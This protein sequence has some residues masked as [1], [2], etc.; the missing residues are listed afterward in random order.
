[1]RRACA[2]IGRVAAAF[3]AL[4]ILDGAAAQEGAA[5]RVGTGDVLQIVVYENPALTGEFGVGAD[6]T[7][8]YP[9]LGRV[10]VG[11]RTLEEVG[12]LLERDVLQQV[13]VSAPPMVTIARYAPVFIVGDVERSGP[14]EFRPGM[15]A[16]ELI[17]LGGGMRRA[18][19]RER[20]MS[21]LIAAEQRLNDLRLS[22][23]TQIALRTRLIAETEGTPLDLSGMP[24]GLV[25]P[26]ARRQIVA[27]EQALFDTR[28]RIL[29]GQIR[30]L[31]AQRTSFDLEI[32][33]LE[34]SIGIRDEEIELLEREVAVQQGLFDRGLSVQSKVLDLKREFSVI[35][36]EAVEAQ[37]FLARAQQRRLEIDQRVQ[38]LLDIRARENA[39]ALREVDIALARLDDEI[40]AAWAMLSEL[41]RVLN[42]PAIS[43]PQAAEFTIV[44]DQDGTRTVVPADLFSELQPRD[45]L[46][47]DSDPAS[48]AA[49]LAAQPEP[50]ID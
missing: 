4:A 48:T 34:E 5:Y 29:D 14:Y 23:F 11:G 35:R 15:I 50:P 24:D 32:A 49:R 6:G 45:I 3:L 19:L 18:S 22:R 9:L 27:N 31:A 42:D 30:A 40:G 44:R 46:R 1:M 16:L 12:D 37:S 8:G 26:E 28:S 7:I 20:G 33:S 43:R 10:P 2:R 47:I 41:R 17:A 36:R 25:S 13:P 38:E 21:E 39:E